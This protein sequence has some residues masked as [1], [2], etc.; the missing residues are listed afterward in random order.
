MKKTKK[1]YLKKWLEYILIYINTLIFCF[2]ACINEINFKGLLI[3]L[4]LLIIF[5]L[6]ALII[7]KYGRIL[8]ELED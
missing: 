7:N 3:I 6:N 5:G 8:K 2:I 1:R 4:L